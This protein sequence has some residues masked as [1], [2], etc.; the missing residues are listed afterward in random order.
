MHLS[1]LDTILTAIAVAIR[2]LHLWT[3]SYIVLMDNNIVADKSCIVTSL[4]SKMSFSSHATFTSII[5]MFG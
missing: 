2:L 3:V 5:G 4:P 1:H